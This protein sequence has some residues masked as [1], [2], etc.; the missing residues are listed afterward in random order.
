MTMPLL[1]IEIALKIA[2]V[3]SA[4]AWMGAVFYGI[5]VLRRVLPGLEP[6]VR[7]GLMV[8]LLPVALRYLPLTAV[9]TIVFGATLYFY[10]GDF[11]PARLWGTLWGQI[12]LIGFVLALLVFAIGMIVSLPAGR[13]ML[14]H[15]QEPQCTHLPEMG[16]LQ[17]RFNQSQLVVMAFGFAIIALMVIAAAFG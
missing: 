10:E 2:H 8:R 17:K 13:K 12:L 5:F 14:G 4:I 3:V 11:D 1:Q 6:P 16:G 7:K 15:L 9:L